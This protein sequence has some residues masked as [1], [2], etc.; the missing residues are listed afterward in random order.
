MQQ[1]IKLTK[2]DLSYIESYKNSGNLSLRVYNR[3]NILLLLSKGKKTVEIEDFL[4]VDRIT[5]WRTKKRYLE[6]GVEKALQED[7]RS[8]QPIK[9][10]TDQQT[11]LSAMACGPCPTGRRRWTI[12][13]LTG[14]LKKKPGFETINRES[15]RLILKKTNVSLG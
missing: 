5:V 10:A 13:L 15:V 8:G 2:T 9:Y 14:E 6:Y 11:E 7:D 3:I 1:S 4:N 12:R